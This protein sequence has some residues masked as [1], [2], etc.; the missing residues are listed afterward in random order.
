MKQLLIHIFSLWLIFP[1]AFAGQ[2]IYAFSSEQESV[3]FAN[4]TRELRCLV[5]QN[6]SLADSDATLAQDLRAKIYSM[7]SEKKSDAEIREF[8]VSRYGK[9]ILFSPPVM[10]S[11]LLLWAFPA[12]LLTMIFGVCWFYRRRG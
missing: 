1:S 12:M 8:L 7:I 9:F 4:L 6:Q 3:R 11:T 5:C 2:D 10:P